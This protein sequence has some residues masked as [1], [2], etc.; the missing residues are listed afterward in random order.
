MYRIFHKNQSE[1]ASQIVWMLARIQPTLVPCEDLQGE[2]IAHRKKG[3]ARAPQTR[4][5]AE[6]LKLD[7]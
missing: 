7:S 6:I 3:N 2:Q 5:E 1:K 4:N